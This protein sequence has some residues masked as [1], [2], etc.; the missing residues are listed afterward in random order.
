MSALMPAH[1]AVADM[2]HATQVETRYVLG[3]LFDPQRIAV[4]L[5]RKQRPDWQRGKLNGIGGKIEAGEV[6]SQ[7]MEREFREETGM[8]ISSWRHFGQFR[9]RTENGLDLVYCWHATASLAEA[10]QLTDEPLEKVSV[11]RLPGWCVYNVYWLV[12]M[13]LTHLERRLPF[14]YDIVEDGL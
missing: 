7:T 9:T 3:F 6:P 14:T 1:A 10:K 2:T 11:R 8:A 12:P 5:I 4:L 13:A